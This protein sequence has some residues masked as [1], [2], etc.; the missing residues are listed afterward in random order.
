MKY[1]LFLIG[2]FPYLIDAQTISID[3][4][5]SLDNTLQ[6]EIENTSPKDYKGWNRKIIKAIDVLTEKEV[7]LKDTLINCQHDSYDDFYIQIENGNYYELIIDASSDDYY[8]IY[9]KE[10]QQE[11]GKLQDM[12]SCIYGE[13]IYPK[14][15]IK[16]NYQGTTVNML[17]LDKKGCVQKIKFL[18]DRKFGLNKSSKKA[19]MKC[20]CSFSPIKKIDKNVNSIFI[21]PLKYRLK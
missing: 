19:I 12:L 1:I 16:N 15:A 7:T 2:L 9:T 18:K 17:Y 8:Y 5:F 10:Y 11:K 14:A 4:I 20:K 6:L 13:I 3:T 21:L